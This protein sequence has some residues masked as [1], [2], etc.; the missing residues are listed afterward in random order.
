MNS[1][2]KII[3]KINKDLGNTLVVRAA[4]A[5]GIGYRRLSTGSL[6]LD[7]I[8]G[9]NSE[10]EWG[11]P[12]GRITEF[13]GVEGSGK[14]TIALNIIKSAQDKGSC[15]AFVNVEG[16]WD[17]SWAERIGVDLDKL[18]FARVPSAETAESV[19]YE[20]IATP[21][22]GVVVLDSIAMMTSQSELETDT[23]KKNVQPGTQPRAV[24]RVVR[25]IASAFNTWPI[26]DPNSIDGQPAVIFLNQLR[27][28]IG[29]YGNPEYS[30]GGKGKDHQASI[31]VQMSKGELHRVNKENK[32]SPAVAMTIK[33]RCNK[34]K[35][36][37]PFQTTEMLLYIRDVKKKG[38]PHNAG[39]IDQ[40]DQLAML[41]LHY[42]LI[43]RRGSVY[44]YDQIS[45]AGFDAFKAELFNFDA[46]A[47]Q[48]KDEILEAA[49]E[50]KGL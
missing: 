12:T 15:G 10:Y 6:S 4:Q 30:P 29:A 13:W 9:G 37:A 19:L 26:D 1:I 17:N 27:E 44:E 33:A 11:V 43:D 25:H 49:W 32:S 21:G 36:W 18:I 50:K 2:D 46:A 41:G 45:V 16:A 14:T 20:L 42:G 39:E 24:N 38:V 48:L 8:C 47:G 40:I 34:N 28:K 35:V 3:D 23:K 31:R 22:V 7:I 5:Q